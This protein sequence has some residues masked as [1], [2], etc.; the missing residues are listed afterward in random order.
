MNFFLK[1][2]GTLL[3]LN[4][5]RLFAR[6]G[7][8]DKRRIGIITG[9]KRSQ[10]DTELVLSDLG[11]VFNRVPSIAA[12]TTPNYSTA[13]DDDKLLYGFI[14]DNNTRTPDT[15]SEAGLGNNLIG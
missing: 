3:T 5:D 6:F 14:V 2:V 8:G 11:N 13:S 7:Q 9:I 15:N 1:S 12:N 4:L 10:Y